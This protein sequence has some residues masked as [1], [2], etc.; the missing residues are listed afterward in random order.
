MIIEVTLINL[1]GETGQT[2]I[3]IYIYLSISK[4][5]EGEKERQKDEGWYWLAISYIWDY[6][7]ER[8]IISAQQKDTKIATNKKKIRNQ[9]NYL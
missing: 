4:W 8:M 7:C 9:S 5:V 2:L 1:F 3:N 6:T